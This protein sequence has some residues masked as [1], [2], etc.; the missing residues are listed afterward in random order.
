LVRFWPPRRRR[1][2]L[3]IAGVVTQAR[4][5]FA[6]EK[7]R[8]DGGAKDRSVRSV[9][10]TYCHAAVMALVDDAAGDAGNTDRERGEYR[11]EPS[12]THHRASNHRQSRCSWRQPFPSSTTQAERLPAMPNAAKPRSKATL[13]FRTNASKRCCSG[14]KTAQPRISIPQSSWRVA[15]AIGSTRR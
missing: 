15:M 11:C 3:S 9:Q 13:S 8:R 10:R 6:K 14:K 7:P 4:K 2:A 1:S 5:R 12:G